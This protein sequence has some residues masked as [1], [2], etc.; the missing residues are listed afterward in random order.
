[1]TS[2]SSQSPA[3]T[4]FS[5]ASCRYCQLFINTLNQNM[6][7][8]QF[9]IIDVGKTAYDVS[10]VRV[11]PTIVVENS[12]ALS[13]REA[14]AWLKNQVESAVRGVESFG[15]SSAFTYIGEDRAECVM[16]SPFVNI[17]DAPEASVEQRSDRNNTED[18]TAAME[19]L[20][21][22]RKM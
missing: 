19:R 21:Q 14:F 20:A 16:S 13:G 3:N 7:M 4:L 6:M 18:V 5:S 1:M 10:K 11:V 2:V 17:E 8:E 12:R 22:E 15:T 9:N